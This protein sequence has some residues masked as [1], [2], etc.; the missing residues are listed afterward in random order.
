[1]TIDESR[2]SDDNEYVAGPE[3]SLAVIEAFGIMN[4]LLTLSEAAELT[5]HSR[6]S[7][8]RSLLTLQRLG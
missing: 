1:M 6:A 2:S 3:K 4:R 5:G 7:V 8:R